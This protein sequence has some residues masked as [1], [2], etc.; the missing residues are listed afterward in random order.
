MHRIQANIVYKNEDLFE[1]SKRTA[2]VH[3]KV[4]E[5]NHKELHSLSNELALLNL[6]KV[7][8]FDTYKIKEKDFISYVKK[9]E[10]KIQSVETHLSPEQISEIKRSRSAMPRWINKRVRYRNVDISIDSN[11]SIYERL[12]TSFNHELKYKKDLK[13]INKLTLGTE[14]HT[15]FVEVDTDMENF[16]FFPAKDT[17]I[18]PDTRSTISLP[19]IVSERSYQHKSYLSAAKVDFDD[20]YQ[21]KKYYSSRHE[22][23]KKGDQL[24]SINFTCHKH[25]RFPEKLV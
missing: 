3:R 17:D 4:N 6:K 22:Y 12:S 18:Q 14:F 9:L 20:V 25:R 7:H 24:A 15:E 8:K 2:E 23:Q 13:Y 16:F 1:L 21:Y 10:Q 5:L 11:K 19:S